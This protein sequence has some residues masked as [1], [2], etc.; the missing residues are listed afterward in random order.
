MATVTSEAVQTYGAWNMGK[1]AA[2]YLIF[3][4]QGSEIVL[5]KSGRDGASWEDLVAEFTTS[6]PSWATFQFRYANRDGDQR[7]KTIL[8]RWAPEDASVQDRMQYS[9]WSKTLK[10]SLSGIAC[11]IQACD[12]GDLDHAVVLE[13]ITRI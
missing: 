12:V 7:C 3:K 6:E 2:G 10:G 11:T 5:A 1:D 13:K 4:L 8:I 9:M